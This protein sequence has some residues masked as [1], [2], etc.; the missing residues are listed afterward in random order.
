[1][2]NISVLIISLFI[3]SMPIV[4]AENTENSISLDIN[5]PKKVNVGDNFTINIDVNVNKNI[6][7]SGFE[8]TVRIPLQNIGSVKIT[9]VTGNEEIKKEAG[10]FYQIKYDNNTAFIKFA[11]F[12]KP[13]N[14][15]FHLMTINAVPLKEGNISFTFRP[16]ASDENGYHIVPNPKIKTIYLMVVNNRDNNNSN[17]LGK[18][19]EN[20]LSTIINAIKNFLKSII[21]G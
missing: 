21:G 9:N 16:I 13:I 17:I 20:F 7:I 2:R 4:F 11:T 6:N 15:N 8:C 19:N 3:F 14:S 10:K 18:S 1:M 12:E 5:M